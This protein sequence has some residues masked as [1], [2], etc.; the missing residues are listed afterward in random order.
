MDNDELLERLKAFTFWSG[1]REMSIEDLA[2]IQPGLGRLMPEIGQRTWKL[3]YA[4][5]AHNWPMAHFQAKEIRGLMEL[6]AFTRPK[7]EAA[8]LEFLDQYWTPLQEAIKK[9]DFAAFEAAFHKAVDAANAYHELKDKPY[10]VWKL[11]ENPP[12][13]LDLSPRK[14]QG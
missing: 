3:Y 12:P 9:E 14:K 2:A 13:D 7:H 10:I 8:L 5:K 1:H 4:A 11:P 6:G